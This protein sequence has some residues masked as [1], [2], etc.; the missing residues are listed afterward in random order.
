MKYGDFKKLTAIKSTDAFIQ[1]LKHTGIDI[2]C[3]E[4]MDTSETSPLLAP[5][6]VDGMRIGNRFVAQPMEG[7][8]CGT[9]GAPTDATFRRWTKFGES[10]AKLIFGGEAAAVRPDGRA[11]PRQ[12]I[13][14][15]KTKGAV[16]KLKE[17]ARKSHLTAVGSESEIG[18]AH[19]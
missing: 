14:N 1:H 8:D 17:S 18:R 15:E 3:D 19:V 10:G 12:L 2:P 9:D 5:I 16:A 6:D 4:S 11:N 13:I 7:W